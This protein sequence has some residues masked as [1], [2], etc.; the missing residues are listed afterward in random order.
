MAVLTTTAFG[1]PVQ[2]WHGIGVFMRTKHNKIKLYTLPVLALEGS[3]AIPVIVENKILRQ[4]ATK[5]QKDREHGAKMYI[6]TADEVLSAISTQQ[7]SSEAGLPEQPSKEQPLF[8]VYSDIKFENM[9]DLLEKIK[10]GLTRK[11]K[12]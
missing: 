12:H 7:L 8:Y 6:Q 4:I 1:D 9:N 11:R 3:N 2:P 10:Q 5:V